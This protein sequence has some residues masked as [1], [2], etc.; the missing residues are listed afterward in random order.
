MHAAVKVL[1]GLVFILVGLGL[2]VDSVYPIM[3]TRGTFGI[4]WIANFI[5]VVTGVIPIML[6]LIG[7]FIVW[8]EADEIKMNKELKTDEEVKTKKK[9]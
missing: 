3:G 2:F 8:L 5:V 6:I 1:I 9:K 7:L 4:D